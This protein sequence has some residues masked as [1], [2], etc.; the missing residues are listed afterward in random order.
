M[1]NTVNVNKANTTVGATFEDI[2]SDP[3]VDLGGEYNILSLRIANIAAVNA[4]TDFQLLVKTHKN[5]DWQ[6]ILT[7][8]DWETANAF[9]LHFVEAPHTLATETAAYV[10]L[11][12]SGLHKV[13]FQA[14]SASGTSL[15]ILGTGW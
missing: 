8:T 6:V 4:I 12:I 13:K 5:A 2:G 7:G 15:T 3:D 10:M 9:L 1:H 14:K 11:H